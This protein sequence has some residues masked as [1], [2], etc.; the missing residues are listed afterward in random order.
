MC[1]GTNVTFTA[2]P[3]NGGSG[4]TYQ[5]KLN[6]VNVGSGGTTYSNNALT[7]SSIVT[8]VMTSN[9]T[10][11]LTGSPATSNSITNIVPAAP[12]A[13]S[14]SA[15]AV[16]AVSAGSSF[17]HFLDGTGKLVV[18]IN[19]GSNNLGTVTAQVFD[20]GPS[21]L[22]QACN[23]GSNPAWTTAVLGRSWKIT[24]QFNL[25]ATVQFPFEDGE[26]SNLVTASN[27]TSSNPRDNVV[28]R[29]GLKMSRFHDNVPGNGNQE[30]GSWSNNCTDGGT[31]IVLAQ[32]GSGDTPFSIVSSQYVQ[33]ATPGFSEF[34]LHGDSNGSPLPV[35]LTAFSATCNS[36]DEVEVN[37]STAS[38]QNSQKFVVEKSRDLNQW[39]FVAEKDA[40]GNSNMEIDYTISDVDAFGGVSYYR[41]VQ[42][43]FDG[44]EK[45]Y[46]PVSVSCSDQKHGMIVFPN[47][48]NG[49][50]T[51]E[52]TSV[53]SLANAEVQLTDL[54]GKLISSRK[55]DLVTGKN[56]VA[57]DESKLQMG[58]Y[59]IK[60]AAGNEFKPVK[61]VV[62]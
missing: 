1:I 61:V 20:H 4:P 9:A 37:W 13:I 14:A 26:M 32:A 39:I 6:G 11:C 23:M 7:N 33:F 21:V 52:V 31:T 34:W 30:D 56:H 38:E 27:N 53:V 3:T 42:I 44:T 29:T 8:C 57:F 28:S 36:N 25:G 2:T 45:V 10:P 60:F 54:T 18:S 50:F 5:W 16:C 48:T 15:T 49:Y 46:Q 17:V 62:N 40:S 58:T 12:S 24:P 47:P 43:D 19:P 51:V 22:T 41:L 35:T 59:F 55:M